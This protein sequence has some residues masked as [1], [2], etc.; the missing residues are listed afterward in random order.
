[1]H[2]YIKKT[3]VVL[4]TLAIFATGSLS[5]GAYNRNHEDKVR[6]TSH[7][8]DTYDYHVNLNYCLEVPGSVTLGIYE[9]EGR[10]TST[11][12]MSTIVD[13]EYRGAGCHTEDWNV[14]IDKTD[15]LYY[16]LNVVGMS[17]YDTYGEDYEAG[18]IQ[19]SPIKVS[20]KSKKKNYYKYDDYDRYDYN[21][22]NYDYNHYRECGDFYDV[23]DNDFYCEAIQWASDEGIFSGYSD[24]SFRPEQSINRA[25][26]LKVVFEALDIDVY[27]RQAYYSNYKDVQRYSWYYDYVATAYYWGIANGYSDGTFRPQEAVSRVAAL[28]ILLDT[29]KEFDGLRMSNNNR[30]SGYRDTQDTYE[31]RWYQRYVD[32]AFENELSSNDDFFYPDYAMTRGELAYMLYRYFQN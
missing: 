5:A 32:Y 28:K 3:L 31:T 2:K 18:W 29:A 6:I 25:E 10:K 11:S 23:D 13:G 1:M 21:D 14:Y 15:E 20:K 8:S 27:N 7:S 16:A 17:A 9:D 19:A 22:R 26:T 4:T 30:Y 24:D 12:L